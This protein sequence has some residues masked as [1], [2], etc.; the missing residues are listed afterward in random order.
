M[1]KGTNFRPTR[2]MRWFQNSLLCPTATTACSVDE[3][4]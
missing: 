4:S 3:A 2:P 1:E